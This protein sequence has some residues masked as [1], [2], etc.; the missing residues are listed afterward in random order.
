VA[1]ASSDNQIGESTPRTVRFL[2]V[3]V[4]RSCEGRRAQVRLGAGAVGVAPAA[5]A[6]GFHGRRF[7]VVG[8]GQ[9]CRPL[10]GSSSP[11]DQTARRHYQRSVGFYFDPAE[12]VRAE[13]ST[14]AF[15]VQS[16]SQR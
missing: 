5:Q 15:R 3:P 1:L 12:D 4:D 10:L 6:L 14:S 2:M 7:D 16:H 9:L 8:E 11:S 13:E